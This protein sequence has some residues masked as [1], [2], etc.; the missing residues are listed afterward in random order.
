MAGRSGR[1]PVHPAGEW[2]RVLVT[3]RERRWA[4]RGGWRAGPGVHA[5][6]PTRAGRLFG[7]SGP[8]DRDRDTGRAVETTQGK[9]RFDRR[10]GRPAGGSS[11]CVV[12]RNRDGWGARAPAQQRTQYALTAGVSRPCQRIPQMR[13]R[14]QMYM[15][16]RMCADESARASRWTLDLAKPLLHPS[17][18][19]LLFRG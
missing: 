11:G 4:E 10:A 2:T 16:T 6:H 1:L 19:G 3:V 9:A 14:V 17:Y 5:P 18:S 7:G 8:V 15:R 12:G 13:S